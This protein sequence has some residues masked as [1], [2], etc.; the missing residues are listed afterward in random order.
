MAAAAIAPTPGT[1]PKKLIE[2]QESLD[3]LWPPAMRGFSR[4]KS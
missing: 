3:V 1:D 4:A 2:R